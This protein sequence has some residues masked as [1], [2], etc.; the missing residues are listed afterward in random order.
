MGKKEELPNLV[1][2]RQGKVQFRKVG[3]RRKDNGKLNFEQA[4]YGEGVN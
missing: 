3:C 2:K 1:R 4:A